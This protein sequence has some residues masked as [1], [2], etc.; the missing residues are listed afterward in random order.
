MPQN[1][2][3]FGQ[4]RGARQFCGQSRSSWR[5]R[6]SDKACLVVTVLSDGLLAGDMDSLASLTSTFLSGCDMRDQ[7]RS[8]T[9]ENASAP[10][11]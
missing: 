11:F 4:V 5:H 9:C 6:S 1:V 8:A 10:H 2:A 7:N 3:P